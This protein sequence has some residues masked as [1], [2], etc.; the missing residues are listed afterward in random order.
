MNAHLA[1]GFISEVLPDKGMARVEFREHDTNEDSKPLVSQPL[2]VSVRKS[3][4]DKETFPYDIGEHV[5]CIMEGDGYDNGV[6]GG[7]LYNA[8][9][10][11]DGAGPDIYRISFKDGSY[12]EFDRAN[13]NR[14]IHV[15]RHARIEAEGDVELIAGENIRMQA[16]TNVLIDADDTIIMNGG[17]NG[18]I[19]KSGA[20]T[21]R[22]NNS[23]NAINDLKTLIGTWTPVP[24]DGGASLKALLSSWCAA[25]LPLTTVDMIKNDKVTH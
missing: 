4:D 12:D 6:I 15:T 25:A 9:D 18:G 14:T 22:H 24:N 21:G 16:D 11:P 8:T 10:L 1:Y 20:L 13:G 23:E 2:P 3:Q 19:P 17:I 7:A 5:W